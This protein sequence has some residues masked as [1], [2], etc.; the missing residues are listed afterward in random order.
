[1]VIKTK[2]SIELL[3]WNGE[4]KEREREKRRRY[5]PVFT[6]WTARHWNGVCLEGEEEKN[7]TNAI[8]RSWF[9]VVK[10]EVIKS[11]FVEHR[12]KERRKKKEK[13]HLVSIFTDSHN[14]R[15]RRI[16]VRLSFSFI[17]VRRRRKK[18]RRRLL[19]NKFNSKLSLSLS[20]FYRRKC[21]VTN[22]RNKRNEILLMNGNV[23]NGMISFLP[24]HLQMLKMVTLRR[25]RQAK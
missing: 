1:M 13:F 3:R 23:M 20:L 2:R 12:K 11:L 10:R 9:L 8:H 15:C 22:Q 21:P 16:F 24:M 14:I 6:C 4:E 19:T 17:T 18:K 7:K 5:L 25:H